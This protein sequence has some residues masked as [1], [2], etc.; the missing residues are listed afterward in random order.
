MR[1]EQ[2]PQVVAERSLA[3]LFSG[4]REDGGG[5]G[6]GGFVCTELT[7][8]SGREARICAKTTAAASI[9]REKGGGDA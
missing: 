7:A 1:G 2:Q 9:Y 3:L 4:R 6:G 8:A 5:G